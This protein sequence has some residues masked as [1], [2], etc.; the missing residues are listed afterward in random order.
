M[1]SLVTDPGGPRAERQQA[2]FTIV[3]VVL[4]MGVLMIGMSVILTLLTF[5]AGMS[6]NSQLRAESAAVVEAVVAD[7][8]EGLFPL[9]EQGVV[10]EPAAIL[11]RL[12]PGHDDLYYT[13]TAV[14]DPS[15]L[16]DLAL[17][18]Q[19]GI[20]LAGGPVPYRVDVQL[21]WRSRGDKKRRSFT[22]L[23]MREVPFGA[24]LRRLFVESNP[25]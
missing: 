22:V 16:D 1:K 24:R 7:L 13:A 10:G 18:G 15:R 20:H 23:I 8:E 2:G 5:G 21:S 14:P 11:D 25:E 19:P 9:D 12:V 4:A 6:R 17:A 3:E